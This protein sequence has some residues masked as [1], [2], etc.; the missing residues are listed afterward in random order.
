[1]DRKCS[2]GAPITWQS[3]TGNCRPCA[4]RLVGKSPAANAKKSEG[5]KRR[6]QIDPTYREKVRDHMRDL[7]NRPEI[8][9]AASERAKANRLSQI[10]KVAFL[11]DPEARERLGRSVRDSRLSWCPPELRSLYTELVKGK[12]IP[13]HEARE[14]I[15]AQHEHDMAVFRRKMGAAA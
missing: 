13:S 9:Q 14:I 1:M 7:H 4:A 3:K 8:K 5:L 15:F 11:A 6:Y 2:C 12:R 10:G